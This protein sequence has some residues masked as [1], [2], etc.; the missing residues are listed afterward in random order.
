M[1]G[2]AS[3]IQFSEKQMVI[4]TEFSK[5]RSVPQFIRQ[6][7]KILCLAFDGQWNEAIAGV[8]G[9]ERHQVGLWR[10]RWAAAWEA[11]TLWECS[12][13]LRLREAIR[14]CLTDAPRAG[15]QGKVTAV[16]VTQI[17]ALACEK[18]ALSQRP[19]T[20]RPIT[21]WTNAELRDEVVKRNIVPSLSV[22]QIGRYLRQAV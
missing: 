6:R 13:P 12:E 15:C 2:K 9:L 5:S 1:P 7:A 11:L 20:Q 21:H 16:Q 18:P 19:I 8:V 22:S 10:R 3:K 14:E 17:L 4:L